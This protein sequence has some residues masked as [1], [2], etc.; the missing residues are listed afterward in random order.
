MKPLLMQKIQLL[1]GRNTQVGGNTSSGSSGSK[2]A[3]ESDASD[4]NSVGSSIR[5]MGRDATKKRPK[6]KKELE[7]LNAI[8]MKQDEANQLM[9]ERTHAKKINMFLKLSE[10]EHHDDRRKK[11]WRS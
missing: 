1:L 4:T 6:R 2:R 10:K 3:H 5:Q 9:K 7:R 11:Y 8:A